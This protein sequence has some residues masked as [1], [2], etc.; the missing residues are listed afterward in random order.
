[1]PKRTTIT[2]ATIGRTIAVT[3]V[4]K[5]GDFGFVDEIFRVATRTKSH[6]RPPTQQTRAGYSAESL[7]TQVGVGIGPLES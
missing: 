1:M 5:V 4:K 7:A 2:C 3:N 6:S